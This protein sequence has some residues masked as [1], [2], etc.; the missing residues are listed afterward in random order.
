M[1]ANRTAA[2]GAWLRLLLCV[3]A[4][5]CLVLL[6]GLATW[7]VLPNV[8]GW[9]TVVVMTGSMQPKVQPGDALVYQPAPASRLQPGQVIIVKDPAHPGRL[10]S[11]RMTERLATGDLIT[12]GDANASADSTPVK[13]DEVLGVAR[14][15]VGYIGLPW[16]WLHEGRPLLAVGA[17]ALTV[18]LAV[19]AGA[20]ADSLSGSD[21]PSGSGGSGGSEGSGGSGT[22]AGKRRKIW[23]LSPRALRKASWPRPSAAR[24]TRGLALSLASALALVVSF[25]PVYSA[26]AKTTVNNANSFT[27]STSFCTSS[28]TI[29]AANLDTYIDGGNGGTHGGETSLLVK[30]DGSRS[31]RTLINFPMPVIP[32]GCTITAATLTLTQKTVKDQ[33]PVSAQRAAAGWDESKGGT[34][35]PALAGIAVA[36]SGTTTTTFEVAALTQAMYP[37]ASAGFGFVVKASDDSD[38]K[39]AVELGYYSREGSATLGPKLSITI[40]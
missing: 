3:L 26:F 10:L 20:G 29:Y 13:P 36:G 33:N 31:K 19:A 5:G 16:R 38:N 39:P 40:G 4:R 14:L 27:A 24:V 6:V 9:H 2:A 21:S 7:A 8:L 18:A 30:A 22:S 15:R 34:S 28:T 11:H 25:S 17:F 35:L 23:A 12:R 32:A 1:S 37:T